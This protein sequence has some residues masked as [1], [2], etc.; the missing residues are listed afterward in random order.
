[1]YKEILELEI[2]CDEI[3]VETR[4]EEILDGYV[5]NFNNGGDVV[6]HQGSYGSKVG[7]VEFGYTGFETIDFYATP[8]K[9]AKDFVLKHKDELNEV[10]ENE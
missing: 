7:C 5:L 1:M 4:K 3:G 6:Q 9:D 10:T 8:L 2:Y